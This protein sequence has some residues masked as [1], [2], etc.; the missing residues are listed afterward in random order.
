MK[1]DFPRPMI[2]QAYVSK[3]KYMAIDNG[4]C[5]GEA[6]RFW[7]GIEA[8]AE[9]YKQHIDDVGEPDDWEG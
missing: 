7:K 2:N 3:C 5:R 9:D 8:H 1:M 6:V 4:F